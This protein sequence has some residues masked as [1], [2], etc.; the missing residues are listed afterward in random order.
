MSRSRF[1]REVILRAVFGLERG[2][3]LDELRDAMTELLSFGESPVSLLPPAQRLLSGLGRMAQFEHA[4]QRST[5]MI[6]ELIEERRARGVDGDDVLSL[7]LSARDEDGSPMSPAELRD[8]LVTA[9]VA[10]HE[11]TASQLAWGFEQ[12]SRQPRVVERLASE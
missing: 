12:L 8:E 7:L 3:Q 4:S 10:G 6:Y 11:T 2:A 5:E 1:T 9:L